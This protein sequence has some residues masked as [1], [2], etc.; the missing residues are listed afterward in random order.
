MTPVPGGAGPARGRGRSLRTRLA[1][2]LSVLMAVVCAAMSVATVLVQGAYLRRDLDQRVVEA[3][4]RSQGVLHVWNGGAQGVQFLRLRGQAAGTLGA[5]TDFRGRVLV[6]GVVDHH[7]RRRQ[8]SAAQCA[9]LDALPLDGSPHTRVVPGLGTYRLTALS[10]GG[11]PVVAGLPTAEGER[12][13]RRLVMLETVIAAAGLVL[14]GG[15]C[16]VTV[17]R[18]LRPLSRVAATAA[19]VAR[20]PLDRGEITGLSRVSPRDADPGTETGQV[21][22]ALNRL[23]DHVERSL[24]GRQRT[25]ERMRR[26]LADVGHE[27]RTPLASIAGYAQLM[28]AG[29]ARTA[30]EVAWRRVSAQSA[31]MTALVE[32]L[33]LLA[34]LDEG[35][36]LERAEVNVATL[37]AEAVWDARAAGDDHR[38]QVALRL[39]P[40]VSVVGDHARLHQVLANLLA[41]AQAHTPPGTHIGVTAVASRDRCEIHVHDDGPG[42]PAALLPSVFERFTR[43]DASR[44]RTAGRPGGTGLGLAIAAAITRAHGGRIDVRSAPGDTEFTVVLPLTGHPVEG[45]PASP[46]GDS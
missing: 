39:G 14:A 6:G 31:R 20:V 18:Q 32:D 16:A 12:L 44:T 42:I 28:T 36:R 34:R 7:G 2:S 19:E 37:V 27:L 8:L 10:D 40:A 9:A 1:L 17:G 43:A 24:A 25:E 45:H 41:N 21:A 46:E 29:S 30:P 26:F 3:A 38:W 13:I 23:I 5:R 35:R 15:I 33:L 11:T 22:A 4:E